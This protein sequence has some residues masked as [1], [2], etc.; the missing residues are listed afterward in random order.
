MNLIFFFAVLFREWYKLNPS[1]NEKHFAD[2]NFNII[3][4]SSYKS[5]ILRVAFATQRETAET[6]WS[7]CFI[8]FTER[9]LCRAL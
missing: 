5:E 2:F 8:K 6:Y 3:H 7:I 1:V 9:P 4:K